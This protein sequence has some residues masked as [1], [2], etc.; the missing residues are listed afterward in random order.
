DDSQVKAKREKFG[1]NELE[2]EAGKPLWAMF[3]DQFKEF[4]V[5][6]LFIAAIVSGFLGEWFDSG[7]IMAIVILNAVIGVFQEYKAEQSLAALKRLSA[8]LAKTLRN[9]HVKP[10]PAQELVP[11]DIIILEAGD[12][13]PADVRLIEAVN[14]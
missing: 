13:V 1:S 10:I 2:E 7:V 6:L 4:L 5:I 14:L 12:F 8:P 3:L 9:R 11:G